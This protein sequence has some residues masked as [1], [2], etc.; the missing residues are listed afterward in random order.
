MKRYKLIVIGADT[1]W[2]E[3]VEADYF[4]TTLDGSTQSGCYAF[5]KD[6]ELIACYPINRTIIS[7]I[8]EIQ[9]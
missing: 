9:N 4:H 1:S 2:D 5:F 3:E 7:K 8:D 6:K